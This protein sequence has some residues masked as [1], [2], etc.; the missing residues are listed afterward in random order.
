MVNFTPGTEDWEYIILLNML[1]VF[2]WAWIVVCLSAF[3][4]GC[5]SLVMSVPHLLHTVSCYVP[6]HL[7]APCFCVG[8]TSNK[9]RNEYLSTV[10]L[11]MCNIL[12]VLRIVYLTCTSHAHFQPSIFSL[13]L[14]LCV[15]VSQLKIILI[16]VK[17]GLDATS[18][19][20]LCLKKDSLAPLPLR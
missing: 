12:T 9:P 16:Y 19:Y 17:L 20:F 8:L 1:Q 18:H 15:C 7:P 3:T 13:R 10:G 6:P 4:M 5:I 11:C 14:Q 2:H